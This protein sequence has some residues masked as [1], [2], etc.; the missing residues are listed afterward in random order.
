MKVVASRPRKVRN[1]NAS[2]AERNLSQ[3]TAKVVT[4]EPERIGGKGQ[5]KQA[6]KRSGSVPTTGCLGRGFHY[7]KRPPLFF[8][9]PLSEPR[10]RKALSQIQ[11]AYKAYLQRR[12]RQFIPFGIELPWKQFNIYKSSE[13]DVRV[14]RGNVEVGS[15]GVKCPESNIPHQPSCSPRRADETSHSTS[16]GAKGQRCKS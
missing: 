6:G 7:L 3:K 15:I 16:E 12:A 14:K 1:N 5:N 8:P 9:I 11:Y 13:G 10:P 4:Q 2:C